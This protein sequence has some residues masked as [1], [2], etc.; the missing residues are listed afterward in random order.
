[1]EKLLNKLPLIC[2]T[3]FLG[4]GLPACK[5]VN[6]DTGT[7]ITPITFD[8]SFETGGS[9]YAMYSVG[10]YLDF[11]TDSDW[12]IPYNL[13]PVIGTYHL[14]PE[15]VKQQ[16]ATMF[17]NGQR[18]IALDLWYSDFTNDGNLADSPVYAHV[19]NAKL[20]KLMPQHES[21]LKSL[22]SDIENTGYELIIFR[23]AT[24]RNSA[25]IGWWPWNQAKYDLNWSFIQ[26]TINTIQQQISGKPIKVLYDL[27]LEIGG[28][29]TGEAVQYCTQLWKDYVEEFG[30]HNSIGFLFAYNEIGKVTKAMTIYDQVGV[31]PDIY[32]FDIY[33]DELAAYT[34]LQSEL[35]DAGEETKPV[36]SEEVYY[37]D[38]DADYQIRQ[39]RTTLKLNI[40]WI[41]QWPVARWA[42]Q[43]GFSVQYPAN[44][45]AYL[46]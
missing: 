31:R 27:E 18:K 38:L 30:S 16:L 45:D 25:P 23:F 7:V 9:N 2:L 40:K 17:A 14:A 12:N 24:Q 8:T 34:E 19:V 5:K 39:A 22:L 29:Q 46:H 11:P 21:N 32:G 4:T 26:S 15:I 37:N 1:M 3:F 36:F 43:N 20:G 33:G 35:K 42:V 28:T 41:M 44:Y 10:S 6:Q 13:R